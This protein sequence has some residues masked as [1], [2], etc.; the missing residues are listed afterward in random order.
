MNRLADIRFNLMKQNNR[1]TQDPIFVVEQ[2]KKIYGFD[3]LYADD[4]VWINEDNEEADPEKADELEDLE[5]TKWSNDEGWSKVYY[6]ERWEFVT[7]C[8]TEQAA[9]DYINRDA[10]NLGPTRIYVYSAYKNEEWRFIR[11]YLSGE[12]V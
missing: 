7:A 8:F 3:S 6:Q 4:Y 5:N 2:R 10:H 12:D 9:Q 11:K 1:L